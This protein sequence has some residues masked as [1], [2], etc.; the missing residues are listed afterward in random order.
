MKLAIVCGEF[1]KEMAQVMVDSAMKTISDAGHT[2]EIFWVPG[3][4]EAPIA[5]QK[6]L[7][8]AEIDAGVFLGYIERGETLHG[9]VMGQVT[10]QVMTEMSL[11]LKKPIGVGVIGPGAT[12]EQAQK[13]KVD[14]AAAAAV[15]AMTMV[16]RLALEN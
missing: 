3:S 13:R 12:L 10:H 9:A 5:M 16:E 8:Q 2:A 14:Y 11:R 15:A 7:E 4:Y 6:M 1:H